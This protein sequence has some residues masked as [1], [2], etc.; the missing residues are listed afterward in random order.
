MAA[1]ALGVALR[2]DLRGA[3]AFACTAATAAA[4]AA[5]S[6]LRCSRAAFWAALRAFLSST[7]AAALLACTPFKRPLFQ[8]SHNRGSGGRIRVQVDCT[9]AGAVGI[10]CGAIDGNGCKGGDNA[11]GGGGV[12]FTACHVKEHSGGGAA[13]RGELA[14]IT[15]G[16]GQN[17]RRVRGFA[18]G[19]GGAIVR[20]GHNQGGGAI[21]V[22][23]KEFTRGGGGKVG[24]LTV[25]GKNLAVNG[26]VFCNGSAGGGGIICSHGMYFP[27][28]IQW[29][30]AR[31]V[32]PGA[33]KI[34]WAYL[35]RC[36]GFVSSTRIV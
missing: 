10:F 31:A 4:F 17:R 13:V 6:A 19:N 20:Y 3:F 14:Q 9:T 25:G 15:A 18:V 5:C 30:V 1:G 32:K 29:S 24:A 35:E 7:K 12:N 36:K 26:L 28:C 11:G 23:V 33:E 2:V 21:P 34:G 22:Q 27:S 8:G 16:G